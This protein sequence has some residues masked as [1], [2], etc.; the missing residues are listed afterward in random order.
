MTI[1]RTISYL[2]EGSEIVGLIYN[3]G[4]TAVPYYYDKNPSGDVVAILDST[5]TAVVK[6]KYDA[7]GRCSWLESTNNDL[8]QS[9]PIRYRSYCYDEDTGLYY[10]NA[11]YYNPQWRRFISPD[12]TEYLDSETPNG[13]NLYAYCGNDPVNYAD[14]SGH[15]GIGLTLLV[16]TGLGLTFGFG[17]EV[18]KQ[19]SDGATIWDLRTWNWDL[20][21][22]NW[23]EIGKASLIG[24][25]TGFA[26]G[27]GG[28]AG[29]IVKGSF[30]ALTIAGHALTVSQSVGLLLGTAAVTNFV[31]GVAGYAMHAVGSETENF[32]I[33]KGV[34]EG[35]GQT[36][37]GTLSFFTAGMYVG[38]GFWNVG[39]G[40]KN[41]FVSM[42]GR[43]A[44][45]YIANYVPNYMFDNIF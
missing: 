38:S 33:L 34:S 26:Y 37:K 29:G 23:W 35:I 44:G 42:L 41:T 25:A 27:L 11:R 12:S 43:A 2:Y 36:G 9:N 13:L 3:N 7:F 4:S 17:I 45:R 21:T 32:N 16:A 15:F 1:T 5:G 8:A 24:A 30:Q 14:P 22:W 31:A 39:V 18:V 28:V 6:Y 20:S 40:A 19:A 10:L